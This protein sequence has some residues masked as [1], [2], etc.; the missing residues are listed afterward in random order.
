M[1]FVSIPKHV[2]N[3][4]KV[5]PL[6]NESRLYLWCPPKTPKRT[7]LTADRERDLFSPRNRKQNSAKQDTL[8]FPPYPLPPTPNKHQSPSILIPPP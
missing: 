1:G 3:L 8:S 6:T 7:A 2:N 4:I 5:T